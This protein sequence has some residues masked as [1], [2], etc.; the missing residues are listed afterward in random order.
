VLHF[1]DLLYAFRL[2]RKSP[3]FTALT[4]LVLAGG[5]AISIY[6]FAVLNTMLYKDL[7]IP[8]GGRVVRVLGEKEGRNV[9][10]NAFI[11]AQ[12][13]PELSTL[14]QVGVY[15]S[16][17]SLLTEGDASRT[18]KTT[19]AEP[20]IFDFTRTRPRLGRGFLQDDAVPGAEAVAV[21]SDK[22]WIAVFAR[23]PGV[24]DQVVRLNGRPTRIVGVMPPRYAFPISAELWLPLSSRESDPTGYSASAFSAYARLRPG[25]TADQAT[26]EVDSLVRRAQAAYRRPNAEELDLDGASVASFQLAQTGPEGA[27]VFG[28]LNVVSVFIL[29]LACVNIGNMLLARINERVREIA[30]RVALGAPRARLMAQMMLESVIIC[31]VGGLLALALAGWALNATNTFLGSTFEGDLPFWWNWGLDTGAVIAAALFIVLAIILVSALPT[32]SATAINANTL[33][34]DGTRG[35]QGRTSGRI[36]RALVTVEIVLISVVMLIGSIIG[37]LAYRA[38]HI[39]FGIDTTHLLTMPIELEGELYD[40]PEEQVLFFQRL[41]AALRQNPAVD[42]AMVLQEAAQTRFAVDDAEYNTIKDYPQAALVVASES[43]EQIGTR[44]L[45]G[46]NFDSRDSAEGL[47]SVV[48]SESIAD[49]YWPDGS[50]LG[51]RIRLV[52]EGVSDEP[53]IVVG[54]VSDVRRGDLFKTTQSS[55]ASLYV[56][57]P[58]I[59]LSAADV[60]VRHQGNAAAGREAMYEAVAQIDPYMAPRRIMDYSEVLEKM[61]LMATTMTELFAT[62][63]IFAI[64]LAMT[65]IYGL[66]ANAVVRRTHEIGLRRA[67]G[68]TDSHIIVLFMRQASRQLAIGLGVSAAIAILILVL[69]GS[70]VGLELPVLLIVGV[71]V[72]LTISALVWLSVYVSTRHAVQHEPSTALRYE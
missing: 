16:S 53:R 51:R 40:T 63:G 30:V 46:R 49:Q 62:C 26:R 45:G 18:I 9:P 66:S 13:R 3:G 23:D 32:Y 47:K 38:S 4:I 67:I 54:I 64:L 39:D 24:I 8:E 21:I 60:I 48:I 15:S 33:L 14:E 31:V 43:P 52:E 19:Y 44:L 5:L 42:A 11:F 1:S 69:A 22:I 6:T 25:V 34:R 65:G 20:T 27:V 71:L 41:L 55:F 35:S 28:V 59:P 61:T 70:M 12:I 50:A 7:P 68:A 17:H 56:P 58:Q 2:L 72:A 29:L 36:S 10:I 57:L 37:I